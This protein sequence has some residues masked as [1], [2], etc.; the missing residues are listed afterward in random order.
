MVCNSPT[1]VASAIMIDSQSILMTLAT[2]SAIW[3]LNI[4]LDI[5]QIVKCKLHLKFGLPN[6]NSFLKPF[7][8][9]FIF[10]TSQNAEEV[11]GNTKEND[12][13]LTVSQ[14]PS[15]PADFQQL[16]CTTFT[17]PRHCDNSRMPLPSLN[18]ADSED[19]WMFLK[20]KDREY[21]KFGKYMDQHPALQPKMRT[22]LLDWLIEVGCGL[23]LD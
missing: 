8:Y 4:L 12:Q 15:T 7:T 2:C 23:L 13:S 20:E 16:S 6:S 17:F 9:H 14:V 5:T 22:I 21:P 18:W 3:K 11:S 10:Q 19:F 1:Y